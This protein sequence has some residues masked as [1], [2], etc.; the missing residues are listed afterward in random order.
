VVLLIDMDKVRNQWP[1]A[2]VTSVNE[3]DQGLV[4]SATVRTA[5]GSILDRPINKLVLLVETSEDEQEKTG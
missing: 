1:M 3:D 2:R 5:S 4:R